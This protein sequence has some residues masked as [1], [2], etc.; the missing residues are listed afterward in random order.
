MSSYEYLK[1]TDYEV[2]LYYTWRF[3]TVLMFAD[4]YDIGQLRRLGYYKT[5][6]IIIMIRSVKGR[7]KNI[8]A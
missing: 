6:C 1:Y 5:F 2:N 8:I 4:A 7:N 3:C